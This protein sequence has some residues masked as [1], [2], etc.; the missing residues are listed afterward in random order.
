MIKPQYKIK[1]ALTVLLLGLL[2]QGLLAAEQTASSLDLTGHWVGW[3]AIGLFVL[4]YGLVMAEEFTALRKSKPVI[5]AA[6]LIWGSIAWIYAAH[7]MT[8]AAEH[9]VR[10]N[11]LE[12]AELMLF[13]LVAMTY[14]NAME[15]RRVFEALRAWLIRGGFGFRSVA[16]AC[17]SASRIC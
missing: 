4:A 10:H 2:P 6:G 3:L 13:L 1:A 7:G 8:T 14:I 15:E 17:R 12:Y 11:L 9:A 16:S 5:I